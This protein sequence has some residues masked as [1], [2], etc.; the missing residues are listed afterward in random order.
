VSPVVHW[1][2][3]VQMVPSVA[4]VPVQISRWQ[5]SPTVHGF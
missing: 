4:A 2:P 5:V 3:S 1:F